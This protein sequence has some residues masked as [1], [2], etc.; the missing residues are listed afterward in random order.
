MNPDAWQVATASAIRREA[1]E[2]R[3]ANRR[4]SRDSQP[5]RRDNLKGRR[6]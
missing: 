5:R 3:E 4:R 2:R 6:P 1:E